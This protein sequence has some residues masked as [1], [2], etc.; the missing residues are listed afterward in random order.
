V[1]TQLPE[2]DKTVTIATCKNAMSETHPTSESVLIRF[3]QRKHPDI[4][5]VD[6]YGSSVRIQLTLGK[7]PLVLEDGVELVVLH[8]PTVNVP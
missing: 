3:L 5:A 4:N 1:L 2:R 6:S 7:E 8:P